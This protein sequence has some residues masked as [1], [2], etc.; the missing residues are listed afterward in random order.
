MLFWL[1]PP[2][3]WFTVFMLVPYAMLFYYSLGSVN[4][5]TFEP[6]FSA[7]N[8]IKVFTTQPYL[9]VMLKSA[10]LGLMTAIFTSILAYPVAF[11]L[12]FYA[13]AGRAKNFLYML[14][15]VPWWASYLVKAYAWK[16]ILGSHGL[17]NQLLLNTGIISHPLTFLLYNEFSVALTLTYIFTP[18]AILSIY[19]QLERIPVS[20]IEGARDLGATGWQIFYKI[21]FPISVPGILAGAVIT[22]S[23]AFG[24]FISP[25]LVG[26]PNSIM[27]SNIVI[28]LLGRAFDWPLAAAIGLVIIGMATA[29]IT[30]ANH[31]ERRLTV[32]L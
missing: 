13:P 5:V 19:S 24:D 25:A 16:T 30:V 14:V 8:F 17:I 22:F 28:N 20:L 23:L 3:L 31:I 6:G 21:V 18:F 7:A 26:G 27:I 1:A 12:A 11:C 29:L 4:Y 2:I 9:G 15:I 32:R 10:K